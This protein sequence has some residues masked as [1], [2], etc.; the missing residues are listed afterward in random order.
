MLKIFKNREKTNNFVIK[1]I[2]AHQKSKTNE[3]KLMK[4][5]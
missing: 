2:Q 1:Q 3:K 4:K 5:K